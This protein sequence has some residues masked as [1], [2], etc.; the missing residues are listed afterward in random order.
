MTNTQITTVLVANRGEIARRIIRT[1]RDEGVR[2]V[3]VYSDADAD[4]LHVRDADVAVHIGAS[5]ARESYLL[6]DRIIDA[7]RRTGAQAIHPGYGFLAEN[8]AFSRACEEAG[9]VFMGPSPS[10]IETMGDKISARAAVEARG[11]PTVPGISRPDLRDEDIIAAAPDVGFPVLIKP[12]AGGGGKGMHKVEDPA[13]LATALVTARREAAGAFG[14]DSL[15]LEHFV[16]TPRHIEVQILADTH[17]NIIHLGERECSLQRRHQKVIEEAPSPLLDDE[18]RDAIGQAA[19]DAARSVGYVGAG[20]V[21]F[22]VPAARPDHFYFMEMNTRLQVE[23]PVTEE[24]TGL[25]LVS[26]QL[27]IARGQELPVVQSDVTFTGHAFE[28]RIYAEDPANGFL[29]TGGRISRV[30]EP[31]GPGVRVD[32]GITDGSEVSS[33]YDPM[34]MKV[35]V[36]GADRAE[37][38]ARLDRAL[39]NTVVA[40]VGVNADFCRFLINVPDVVAGKLDTGLLDRVVDD[41][42]PSEVPDDAL[43]ATAMVWLARRWPTRPGSAW[44]IPDAWRAGQPA[45]Q[46]VRLAWEGGSTLVSVTGTP[47]SAEVIVHDNVAGITDGDVDRRPSRTVTASVHSDGES[48]RVTADGLTHR[49]NVQIT[50]DGPAVEIVVSSDEGTWVLRREQVARSKA[51]QDAAGDGTL[52]SPMPGTIT[53]LSVEEGALV[54]AGDAVLVVEAMKMEHVLRAA[55]DG[56]VTFHC[57]AGGQVPAGKPLATIEPVL[58]G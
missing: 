1:L 55:E 16:D 37:A 51:N 12:S 34:L 38:L 15:F 30:V 47:T 43:V 50:D 27:A 28:A 25:D 8:A 53:A 7:A 48:W 3:A 26:L 13:E 4:A 46:R 14:D 10:A 58:V 45:P 44:A 2:S 52:S 23:H 20:T 56:T 49:W 31:T 24:I 11:V 29:P 54:S 35:I 18:A 32:S 41:Y 21:E 57:A 33:L 22:I 39:A 5:P 40:G 9:I 6:I 42:I 36:H 17:G 19:C